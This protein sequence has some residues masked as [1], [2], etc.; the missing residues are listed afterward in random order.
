MALINVLFL[1]QAEMKTEREKLEK[2]KQQAQAELAE[3]QEALDQDRQAL[4][5]EK[6][7]MMAQ[8]VSESDIIS[9]NVGGEIMQVSRST[10]CQVEVSFCLMELVLHPCSD[11]HFWVALLFFRVLFWLP[12]FLVDGNKVCQK[13]SRATYF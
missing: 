13:I 5:L 3:Q 11:Y 1:L 6:Q 8:H 4:A 2:E 10:L 9:L 7:K 12:C